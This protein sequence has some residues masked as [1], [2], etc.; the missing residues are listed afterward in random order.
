MLLADTEKMEHVLQEASSTLRLSSPAHNRPLRR[1]PQLLA[2][3]RTTS[4][5]I[6]A[7]AN[8]FPA[9][10]VLYGSATA[11]N[12]PPKLPAPPRSASLIE[13]GLTNLLLGHVKPA[14]FLE[15]EGYA[16][17]SNNP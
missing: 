16:N 3:R 15:F 5:V 8:S 9:P 13:V 4:P 17:H 11:R 1:G 12:P 14:C 10:D 7:V 2:R 6:L